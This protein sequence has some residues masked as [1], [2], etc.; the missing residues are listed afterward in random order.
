MP[1]PKSVRTCSARDHESP[2]WSGQCPGGGE[3]NAVVEELL[4]KWYAYDLKVTRL[5]TLASGY[6]VH[7]R[8]W[9]ARRFASLERPRAAI[10]KQVSL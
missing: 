7:I 1:S 4:G 3:S 5:D 8:H 2:R 9:Y 6:R 10:W